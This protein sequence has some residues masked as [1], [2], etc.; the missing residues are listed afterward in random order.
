MVIPVTCL[1]F[2]TTGNLLQHVCS[3][4]V[5]ESNIPSPGSILCSKFALL[6]PSV[7]P[8]N[9][10]TGVVFSHQHTRRNFLGPNIFDSFSNRFTRPNSIS[11]G[12]AVGKKATNHLITYIDTPILTREGSYFLYPIK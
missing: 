6:F 8:S 12:R 11:T 4:W 5:F 10:P 1:V 3:E 2:K 9:Y 7:P